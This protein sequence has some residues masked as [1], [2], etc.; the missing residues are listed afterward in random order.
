MAVL[1]VSIISTIGAFVLVTNSALSF[2]PFIGLRGQLPK[3]IIYVEG[4]L[5]VVSCALFLTGSIIAFWESLKATTGQGGYFGW[6]LEDYETVATEEPKESSAEKGDIV[7]D[8]KAEEALLF[9]QVHHFHKNSSH[10]NLFDHRRGPD[11]DDEPSSLPPSQP[12][13]YPPSRASSP[14]PSYREPHLPPPSYSEVI[15]VVETAHLTWKHVFSAHGFHE[16]YSNLG[17]FASAIFLC[18]S[19]IY[20]VTALLSLITIIQMGEVWRAIRY[21]QLVAGSG[22]TIG[23]LLLLFKTQKDT[24]G[25]WFKPALRRLAWHVNLWNLIGSAGFVFC[26]LFGLYAPVHWSDFQFNCSYLW[27]SWAFLFGSMIQWYKARHKM[28]FVK[29]LDAKRASVVREKQL[30]RQAK[31]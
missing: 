11:V 8:K 17:L 15:T 19:F 27:G 29:R 14:P 5:S 18:S 16:I 13:S 22:F 31:P 30:T 4:I 21:P 25:S 23:S 20:F 26:A 24:T 28:K 2:L 7:G 3:S 9:P 6:E 1:R 10:V 12:P